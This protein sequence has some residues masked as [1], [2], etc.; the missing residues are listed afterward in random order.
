MRHEQQFEDMIGKVKGHITTYYELMLLKGTEK[1]SFV[2]SE[3]GSRLLIVP[4]IVF[5]AFFLSFGAAYYISSVLENKY[6]GFLII[7]GAYLILAFLVLSFR[8]TLLARPFRNRIIK[9]MCKEQSF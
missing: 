8:K 1:I 3:I 9:E 4:I 6:L 5:S 7:G 2:L